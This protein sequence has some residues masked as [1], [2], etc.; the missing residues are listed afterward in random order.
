MKSLSMTTKQ[1]AL[2]LST[3]SSK[4]VVQDDLKNI[5]LNKS[6]KL[7]SP[8]DI[9]KLHGQV[10]PDRAARLSQLEGDLPTNV[11]PIVV[12]HFT[13]GG[14][15]KTTVLTN[16]AIELARQGLKV[17][18]IDADPQGTSTTLFGVDVDD[19]NIRT[20]QNVLFGYNG[21][22]TPIKS[23]IIPLYEDAVLD[24]IPSDLGLSTFDLEAYP[25]KLREFLVKNLIKDNKDFFSQ[26]DIVLVD[27]NP[28]SNL[29]NLN[30]MIA[31][32]NIFMPVSLDIL[33]VKSMRLMAAELQ[34]VQSTD[35]RKRNMIV[36]G[37]CYQAGTRHGEASLESLQ[38]NYPL[39][40]MATVIPS[41]A[42]VKRQGW[43]GIDHPQI[44]IEIEPNSPAA[45][46]LSQLAVELAN[47]LMWAEPNNKIN[48]D[49][50][51]A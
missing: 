27:T 48:N 43:G 41:Y 15:G 19:A 18:F 4:L 22:S 11:P 40:M 13:K 35:N 26:Y 50:K 42:G 46:K 30:L 1:A 10:R 5:L 28:G 8:M 45:K 44:L 24:L 25:K 16:V 31:A 7:I 51:V 39:E 20:L 17:L 23:A 34:E 47:R 49:L 9:R 32:D 29:L 37:N 33:S 12:C 14:V 38:K 3:V 2:L 6:S 36:V 21:T